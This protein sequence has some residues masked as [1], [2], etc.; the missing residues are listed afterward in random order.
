M[1]EGQIVTEGQITACM[2]V[3]LL[4]HECPHLDPNP[5]CSLNHICHNEM[6]MLL[7]ENTVTLES[8]RDVQAREPDHMCAWGW[9]VCQGW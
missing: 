4:T 5:G 1:T 2:S 9:D 6:T 7:C 3:W 8:A